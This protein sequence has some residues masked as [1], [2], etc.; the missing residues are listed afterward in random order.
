MGTNKTVTVYHWGNLHGWPKLSVFVFN[1]RPVYM[2]MKKFLII[3]LFSIF[4]ALQRSIVNW[5]VASKELAEEIFSCINDRV[6][7]VFENAES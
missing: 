7:A 2:R 5:L 4:K 6:W 3:I 1:S